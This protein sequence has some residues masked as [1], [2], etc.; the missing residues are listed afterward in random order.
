ME[1]LQK[2][3]L[4]PRTIAKKKI[5]NLNLFNIFFSSQ[6]EQ[7]YFDIGVLHQFGTTQKV[8]HF[9]SRSLHPNIEGGGGVNDADR[10]RMRRRVIM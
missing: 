4:S 3:S 5:Q 1:D 2:P 9:F 8:I 6:N 10:F 7:N